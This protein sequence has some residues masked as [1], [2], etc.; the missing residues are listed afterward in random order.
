MS[1]CIVHLQQHPSKMDEE[2]D[3]LSLWIFMQN[4]NILCQ[5]LHE[6]VVISFS[7]HHLQLGQGYHSRPPQD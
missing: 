5:H 2:S 1:W 4:I 3:T 6:G 7:S